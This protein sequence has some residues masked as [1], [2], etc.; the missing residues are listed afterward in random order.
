[1]CNRAGGIAWMRHPSGIQ[2]RYSASAAACSGGGSTAWM[3]VGAA[4]MQL[5]AAAERVDLMSRCDG[6]GRAARESAASVGANRP[7]C[8]RPAFSWVS[9]STVSTFLCMSSS[10]AVRKSHRCLI[11]I[12]SDCWHSSSSLARCSSWIHIVCLRSCIIHAR[13]QT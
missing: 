6:R 12:T 2:R 5:V 3:P 4:L 10:S 8:S 13:S 11:H 7:D 1:M 9:V